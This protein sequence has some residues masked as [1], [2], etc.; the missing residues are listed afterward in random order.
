M[1]YN[2]IFRE[3]FKSGGF[4]FLLCLI[5]IIFIP[6][7]NIYETWFHYFEMSIL[8]YFFK[9]ECKNDGFSLSRITM[10][11]NISFLPRLTNRTSIIAMDNVLPCQFLAY[12][13]KN[14]T[15]AFSTFFFFFKKG[16]KPERRDIQTRNG[17]FV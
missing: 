9:I 1:I 17:R 6:D 3:S 15:C 14:A 10:F 12:I 7:R 11:K 16:K 13:E 5:F 4:F 2:W 8:Y